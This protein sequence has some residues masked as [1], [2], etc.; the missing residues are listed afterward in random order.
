MK[1]RPGQLIIQRDDISRSAI[2]YKI[3]AMKAYMENRTGNGI[4]R[5][6]H[7]NILDGTP[8]IFLGVAYEQVMLNTH[9]TPRWIKILYG[10]Q[11]LIVDESQ[12]EES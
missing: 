7:L 2:G 12:F 6:D 11:L 3:E 4:S 10:D 9:K 1:F 5:D 8:V